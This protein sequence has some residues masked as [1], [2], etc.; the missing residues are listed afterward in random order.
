[1]TPL[2][3]VNTYGEGDWS[4]I[5]TYVAAGVPS[6]GQVV[7]TLDKVGA[8]DLR[9]SWGLPGGGDGGSPIIGF[10]PTPQPPGRKSAIEGR[11]KTCV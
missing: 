2:V 11:G 8:S 6:F 10:L 9:V 5:V 3:E 4:D 1:M 7:P